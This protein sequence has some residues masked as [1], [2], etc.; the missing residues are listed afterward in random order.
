MFVINLD[1]S[2]TNV[3]NHFQYKRPIWFQKL[4]KYQR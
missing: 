2:V 1:K 4:M 3:G